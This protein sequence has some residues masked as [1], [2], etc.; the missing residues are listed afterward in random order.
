MAVIPGLTQEEQDRVY[1]ITN[2][3]NDFNDT[4]LRICAEMNK[5][6][7]NQVLVSKQDINNIIKYALLYNQGLVREQKE[8]KSKIEKNENVTSF[9]M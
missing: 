8:L 2:S 6:D 1:E 7:D 4:Y 5:T 9:K 3:I